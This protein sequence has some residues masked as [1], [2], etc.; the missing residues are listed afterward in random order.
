MFKKENLKRPSKNES[1]ATF[2]KKTF[3]EKEIKDGNTL[4]KDLNWKKP[5]TIHVEH[6]NDKRNVC[7]YENVFCQESALKYL[8]EDVSV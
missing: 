5:R 7:T 3:N 2:R 6:F 1:K 4:H 8:D